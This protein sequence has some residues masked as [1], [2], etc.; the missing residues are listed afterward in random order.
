MQATITNTSNCPYPLDLAS[1]GRR[2]IDPGTSVTDDWRDEVVT[3][4]RDAR[5]C[6]VVEVESA[7]SLRDQA[8]ALGIKLR[9]NMTDEDISTAILERLTAP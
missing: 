7:P 5:T 6:F 3:V 2:T 8:K 1:G 4:L 9:K